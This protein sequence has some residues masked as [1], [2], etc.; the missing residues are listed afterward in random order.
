MESTVSHLK[1]CLP[2]WEK[3][4]DAQQTLLT[5]RSGWVTYGRGE[6]IHRGDEECVGLIL[7]ETGQFRVCMLSEDGREI[8]LYR[9][10]PGDVCV[11]SA[12]CVL[13]AITFDVFVEAVEDTRML[14]IPADS[15]RQVMEENI[16]AEA[17]SYK[18]ATLR[19]SEV[20]WTMQQILFMGVDRRLAIFL[21]D[22]I[23]RTGSDTLHLTHEQVARYM[24]TAREVVSRMLKYFA[25][26]GLV[27]LSRGG[28]QVTDRKR[29]R[30]MT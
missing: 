13:E 5:T 3:L 18:T 20:M 27:A 19:F 11:L 9:L 28:I 16:Y 10:Y 14:N 23:A 15:F 17:F 24:G 22:E 7:V 30:E 1:R 29:L 6:T 4:T 8:T 21:L 26:E 2:F 25:S 12:S